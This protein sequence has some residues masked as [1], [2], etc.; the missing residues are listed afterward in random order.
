MDL[1]S[2]TARLFENASTMGM[3]YL[4]CVPTAPS[5]A[6]AVAWP[7]RLVVANMYVSL[8]ASAKVAPYRRVNTKPPLLYHHKKITAVW[9]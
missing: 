9:Q 1:I 2:D 5:C 7:K 8:H 6:Q 3:I 4:R